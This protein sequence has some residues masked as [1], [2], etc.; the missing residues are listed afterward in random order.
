M[1]EEYLKDRWGNPIT[2]NTYYTLD[3]KEVLMLA[4]EGGYGYW[5]MEKTGTRCKGGLFISGLSYE[6]S[7]R[8]EPINLGDHMDFLRKKINWMEKMIKEKGSKG[9]RS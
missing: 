7:K 4:E 1:S 3:N 6:E 2:N 8:L 9:S 5:V